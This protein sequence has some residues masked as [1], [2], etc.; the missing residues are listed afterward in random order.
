[1][2]LSILVVRYQIRV[3]T[4]NL[5][6]AGTEAIVNIILEGDRGD[7]G[8]RTLWD[9]ETQNCQAFARGRVSQSE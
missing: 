3:N 8:P 1:M 7:T 2:V 6:N 5:W 9:P 4:G